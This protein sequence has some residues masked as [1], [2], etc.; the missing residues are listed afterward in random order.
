MI[1]LEILVEILSS[2]DKALDCLKKFDFIKESFTEDIYYI[3]P[4]RDT[5][6]PKN[7]RLNASFRLRN[8][9]DYSFITFKHDHFHGDK[10]LYSD[11]NE[12]EIGDFFVAQQIL[13]QL[14]FEKMVV[15]KNLKRVYKHKSFE[16]VL[17]KVEK[18]GIF[19]EVELKEEILESDVV[20]KKETIQ[21]FIDSLGVS[22]SSELNCGKPELY[23]RKFGHFKTI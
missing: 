19:L 9:G 18:L 1:E 4:L 15:L 8:Q 7:L 6:Q 11:E 2:Y 22:V 20:S 10:W 3:D 23:L 13:K 12:T 16:I 14:G 17:E 21:N 5:L